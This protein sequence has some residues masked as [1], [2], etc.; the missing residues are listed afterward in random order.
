MNLFK[1]LLRWWSSP[2]VD[3]SRRALIKGAGALAVAA[4]LAPALATHSFTVATAEFPLDASWSIMQ[5]VEQRATE[6]IMAAEDARVMAILE[7]LAS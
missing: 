2:T 4:L 1:K 5:H 6:E 3:E 7:G